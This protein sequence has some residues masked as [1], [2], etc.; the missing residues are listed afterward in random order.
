MNPYDQQVRDTLA[1][2]GAKEK[3]LQ[4]AIITRNAEGARSDDWGPRAGQWASPQY[5]EANLAY[6][7]ALLLIERI[8]KELVDL[9]GQLA[10]LKKLQ[11]EVNKA[12]AV[13]IANGVT[14]EAAYLMAS[15]DAERAKLVNSIIKWVALVVGALVAVYAISLFIRWKR[16]KK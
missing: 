1:Q 6:N 13:A 9:R 14:P 5:I 8:N 3:E 15:T 12:A 16:S 4:S 7:A 10:S 11:A 2:I